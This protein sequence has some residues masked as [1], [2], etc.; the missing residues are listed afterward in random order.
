MYIY[1]NP[2][3]PEFRWDT[4]KL[5]PLLSSVRYHQG[6][7]VGRMGT[8]GFELQNQANLQI[9]TLDVLKTTEIEG[10]ILNPDQVRSSLARRLGLKIPGLV[11]SGRDVDGIVEMMLD[12]TRHFDRELTKERLLS[13]HHTLFPRGYSGIKKISVGCFR[14]D[15]AGPMQILSGPM[16]RERVH[17]QA[18]GAEVLDGEMDRFLEWIKEAQDID[19]ILKAG[20]AHLWFV[21]LHPFDDGNGRIARAITDMLL[22]QSDGQSLRFYS[23]SSQIRRE[24]KDYYD[25][26]ERTQ[27]GGLEITGWLEWFLICLLHSL[28]SSETVL[29]KV[30]FKHNFWLENAR[31]ID[32]PRQRKVLNLLIDGFEGKLNTSKWA[33]ICGCSQDTALRDIQDLLDKQILYKL[34]GGGRSTGYDIRMGGKG[35]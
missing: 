29:G 11:E 18:P 12:A 34:P 14:D 31:K 1:E 2:K 33:K 6:K 16:G 25:H 9:L 5:L 21:T 30:I 20:I 19:L 8:L 7:L 4:G 26:L 28:E 35:L 10:E 32:N 3:W 15:S 17:F 27:K 23:M 22:A 24:R 13:W